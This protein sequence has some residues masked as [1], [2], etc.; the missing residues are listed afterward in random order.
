[1]TSTRSISTVS[2]ALGSILLLCSASCSGGKDKSSSGDTPAKAAPKATPKAAPSAAPEKQSPP[3]APVQ[4]RNAQTFANIHVGGQPTP[5][6]LRQAATAGVTTV[7]NLRAL[8]EPGVA[9]EAQ[10]A[11]QLGVQYVAIPVSSAG[12]LTPA[13]ART[14]DEALSA[15]GDKPVI[16]HCA[17]G[18]RVGALF[19]IRAHTVL[20]QSAEQALAIG[21]QYGLSRLE[22]AVRQQLGLE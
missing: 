18:N 16:V 5:E 22:D 1:M 8:D 17:S 2:V 11:Q 10:L 15:A 7:V 21:K 9:E 14:L 4:F 12:D 19:A 20:K 13:A 6:E 3:A